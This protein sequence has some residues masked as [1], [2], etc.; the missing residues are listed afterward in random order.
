MRGMVVFSLTTA[1]MDSRDVRGAGWRMY[2][3]SVLEKLVL[4]TQVLVSLLL[5]IRL[6]SFTRGYSLFLIYQY[7]TIGTTFDGEVRR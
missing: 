5:R 2:T 3:V 4:G 6:C 7:F 1:R